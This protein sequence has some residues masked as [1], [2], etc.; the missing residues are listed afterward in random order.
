MINMLKKREEKMNKMGC[1]MEYINRG[2][3]QFSSVAIEV[4]ALKK[5]ITWIFYSYKNIFSSVQSLSHV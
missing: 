3:V 1:K 2:S 4:K 5:R